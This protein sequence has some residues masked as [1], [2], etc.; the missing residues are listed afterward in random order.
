MTPSPIVKLP[1][2]VNIV[3]IG[4]PL[5]ETSARDQ[6][7]SAIGVGWR[8]P[9]GGDVDVVA[10]LGRLLGPKAAI[11]DKANTEVIHRLNEG[12]PL[13][14]GVE[15]AGAVIP[16]MG[17]GQCFTAALRLTGMICPTRCSARSRRPS[18]RKAGQAI[19]PVPQLL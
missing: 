10:A 9:G 3:N 19:L 14:K 12:V 18:S 4:L 1:E 11:I 7:A 5:F 17:R 16:N 2:A 15:S 8:I 13:L 6:G